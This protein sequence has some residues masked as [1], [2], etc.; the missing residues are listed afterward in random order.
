MKQLNSIVILLLLSGVMATDLQARTFYFGAKAGSSRNTVSDRT[1]GYWEP[2]KGINGGVFTTYTF[3]DSAQ[4]RAELNYS[5]RDF[6]ASAGDF[7]GYL[8]ASYLEIA[9]LGALVPRDNPDMRVLIGPVFSRYMTGTY[10]FTGAPQDFPFHGNS[11]LRPDDFHPWDYSICLGVEHFYKFLV[12][13]LRY[14]WGLNPVIN[15]DLYPNNEFTL[16]YRS[17]K[18]EVGI[19]I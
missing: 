2:Y 8:S 6:Q 3:L 1:H 18:F 11:D 5:T 9:L 19:R 15:Q 16:K 12:F 17:L 13:D 4:L 14:L 7:N 10:N